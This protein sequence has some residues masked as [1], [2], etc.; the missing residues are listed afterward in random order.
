MKLNTYS[1]VLA[2][3]CLCTS[4]ALTVSPALADNKEAPAGQPGWSMPQQNPTGIMNSQAQFP[5]G[6]NPKQMDEKNSIENA[7]ESVTE[8]A[9]SKNGFGDVIDNLTDQ[10]RTRLQKDKQSSESSDAL[11]QK[12]DQLKDAWKNKYN[13]SFNIKNDKAYDGFLHIQTGEIADPNQLVGKWPV[14]A[15]NIAN[16]NASNTGGEAS[17]QDV[18]DAKNHYFGGDV[19]LDKGRDVALVEAPGVSGA[20]SLTSSMIHEAG[21]WKFDIPNNISRQQLH[22]TLLNNLS[23]LY[24]HQNQWPSDAQQAYRE[25]TQYVVAS[26]YNIDLSHASRQA[27][28]NVTNSVKNGTANNR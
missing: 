1:H 9:F 7:F 20:P 11:S 27:L 26:L 8:S 2:A 4:A 17:A 24:D 5:A 18:K 16:D 15:A 23:Y 25:A 19:N 21:G 14:Q 3:A 22:Q 12:M 13:K 10:D 6:I 28:N